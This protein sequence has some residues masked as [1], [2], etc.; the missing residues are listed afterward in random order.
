MTGLVGNCGR[1]A[2]RTPYPGT[3]RSSQKS[4]GIPCPIKCRGSVVMVAT[5]QLPLEGEI[6]EKFVKLEGFCESTDMCVKIRESCSPPQ[7]LQNGVLSDVGNLLDV[8][9]D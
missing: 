2:E 6:E 1:C 4:T 5:P 7:G 3:P 9:F 8:E